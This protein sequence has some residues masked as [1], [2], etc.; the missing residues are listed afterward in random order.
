MKPTQY[1]VTC[2]LVI[3]G[4]SHANAVARALDA[5]CRP[6]NPVVVTVRRAHGKARE[7]V[8]QTQTAKPT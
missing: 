8:V 2:K 6:Q 1:I 3:F 7:V 4:T 5:L